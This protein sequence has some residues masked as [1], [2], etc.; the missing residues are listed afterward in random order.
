MPVLAMPETEGRLRPE[1]PVH[2]YRLEPA[3]LVAVLP[4][5]LLR[6]AQGLPRVRDDDRIRV[7]PAHPVHP[8]VI[9]QSGATEGSFR[10]RFRMIRQVEGQLAR[11][12]VAPPDDQGRPGG[13]VPLLAVGL[14]V[15]G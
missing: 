12:L 3:H 6:V 11:R 10:L 8:E 14:H 15:R 9:S 4:Q 5:T 1:T 13:S 2:R 7:Q